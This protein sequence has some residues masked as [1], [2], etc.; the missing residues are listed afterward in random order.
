MKCLAIMS[1]GYV[2]NYSII[3]DDFTHLSLKPDSA[4]FFLLSA[5]SFSLNKATHSYPRRQLWHSL[6]V[7]RWSGLL[8]CLHIQLHQ[9]PVSFLELWEGVHHVHQYWLACCL[10][11]E[12][13]MWCAAGIL[14][15]RTMSNLLSQAFIQHIEHIWL[16]IFHQLQYVSLTCHTLVWIKIL[17]YCKTFLRW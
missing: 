15:L 8:K 3:L 2:S 4:M 14:F 12:L 16:V 5:L 10:Q 11:F 6:F 1:A 13:Y 17:I 9:G 7:P